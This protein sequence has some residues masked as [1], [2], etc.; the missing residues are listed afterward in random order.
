MSK[1]KVINVT[2]FSVITTQAIRGFQTPQSLVET[3]AG[4]SYHVVVCVD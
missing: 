3:H 2:Q 1:G 4:P